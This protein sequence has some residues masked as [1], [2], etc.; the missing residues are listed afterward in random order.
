MRIFLV[1]HAHAGSREARNGAPDHE[2]PLSAK[3]WARANDLAGVLADQG[4]GRLL[5]SHYLRCTQTLGP[6]ASSLGLDVEEHPALAE[7]APLAPG[8]ELVEAL[9]TAG[10]TAALCS[11]G[12]VIPELLAGLARRGTVLDPNG[13]CPK[14]SVWVLTAADGEITHAL[15]AGTDGLPLG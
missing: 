12:D 8:I 15:Y 6:L 11:H 9:V 1:R 5:S 10:Q 14:G 2:R 4:I 7:G 13:R 3:G